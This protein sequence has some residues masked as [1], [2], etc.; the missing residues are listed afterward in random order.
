MALTSWEPFEEI[1]PLREA[2]NRLIEGR[3]T[4]PWR[5]EPFGRAFAMDI[6]DTEKEYIIEAS[7]P[8]VKPEDVQVSVLGP[9]MT[10]RAVRKPGEKSDKTTTYLRRERYEGEL[11]RT[12][13]FSGPIDPDKVEATYEHGVLT[14]LVP[15]APHGH[16]TKIP[17]QVKE[18]VMAH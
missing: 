15:K 5:F 18:P 9:T 12:V 2:M 6:R 8:G 16:T 7:L 1:I 17:I 11:T 3:L 10:I 14:L 13:E 4:A